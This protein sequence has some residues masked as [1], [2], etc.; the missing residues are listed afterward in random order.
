[1]LCYPQ[2]YPCP[3]RASRGDLIADLPKS[4]GGDEHS[5]GD[6]Y[7]TAVRKRLSQRL[8]WRSDRIRCS[9]YGLSYR[10]R[11]LRSGPTLLYRARFS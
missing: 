4:I 3:H 6:R 10:I 9:A 2:S 5:R 7:L 8:L 1:V 11:S